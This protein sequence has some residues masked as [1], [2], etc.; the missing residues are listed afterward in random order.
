[1]RKSHLTQVVAV[2]QG[3]L[4][5]RLACGRQAV[6]EPLGQWAGL[7]VAG[8]VGVLAGFVPGDQFQ[9]AQGGLRGSLGH[10]PKGIQRQRPARGLGRQEKQLVELLRDHGLEQRK[11]RAQGLADARAGLGHQAAPGAHRL[12]QGLG[13]LPLALAELR[14]GKRQRLEALVTLGQAALLALG[15]GQ[16][17]LA[18][19]FEEGAQGI[20]TVVFADQRLAVVV[21]VQVHQRYLDGGQLPRLAQE[22][23]IDLGLGPVQLAMVGRLARQVAAVGLDLLQAVGDRV[24]AVGT[25]AHL[26]AL[27][28]AFEGDFRLIAGST[29]GHHP[30]VAFDT[31]LSRGRWGEAQVQVTH[32]G[33][34]LAQGA[35]CHPVAHAGSLQRT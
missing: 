33:T 20:G 6:V 3:A 7:A 19:G 13:Q 16:E 24:V 22:P 2:Q 23:G 12:V 14:V 25:A 29:P 28:M 15:P 10:L 18:L 9:G 4:R 31:L 34:E 30:T 5:R 26:Q 17:A 35:H 1:M 21:D 27:V 8:L 11:Q 32:L